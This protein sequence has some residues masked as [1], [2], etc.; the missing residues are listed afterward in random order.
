MSQVILMYVL[1]QA[2]EWGFWKGG[3]DGVIEMHSMCVWLGGRVMGSVRSDTYHWCHGRCP[4]Q[5]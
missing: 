1:M 3:W 4:C 5:G 2:D